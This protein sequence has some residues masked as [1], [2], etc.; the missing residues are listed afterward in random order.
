MERVLEI[1][2][3]GKVTPCSE[4]DYQTDSLLVKM[5]GAMILSV[6]QN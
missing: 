5:L 3:C 6:K 4:S 1:F 2:F